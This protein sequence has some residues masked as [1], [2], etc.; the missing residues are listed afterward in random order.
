MPSFSAGWRSSA[1]PFMENLDFIYDLKLRAGWGKNGNQEGIPNYARYGLVNYYRRTL[2]SPLSGPAS[3]Q[4]TYGNPDLRWEKTAQTDAGIELGLFGGRITLEA[5]YYY[6]LTTDMLLDAP[7]PNTSGYG[8]IRRN[9]GSMYNK[10]VE[11]A[12]NTINIDRGGFQ[13][14]TN[15]NISFNRNK[16]LSLATPSDIFNVGGPNFTNPTNIIS[17]FTTIIG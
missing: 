2:T 16:V 5:D 15:F 12:L 6:R 1:E 4:T 17:G 13:W 10:G 8:T 9:V 14:N 7:V 3:V 11:L